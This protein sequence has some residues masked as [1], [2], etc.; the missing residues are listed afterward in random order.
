MNDL[1]YMSKVLVGSRIAK[2]VFL[3][4]GPDPGDCLISTPISSGTTRSNTCVLTLSCSCSFC[5][6][7]VRIDEFLS[8]DYGID[9]VSILS[10]YLVSIWSVYLDSDFLVL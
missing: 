4:L 9:L 3:V 6:E 8:G 7:L 2:T 1:L 5:G 10:V